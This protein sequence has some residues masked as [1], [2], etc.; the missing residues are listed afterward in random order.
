MK[1]NGFKVSICIVLVLALLVIPLAGCSKTAGGQPD[2]AT[3][4]TIPP[5]SSFIIDFGNFMSPNQVTSSPG[6][7][8]LN[9]RPISFLPGNALS[10]PGGYDIGDFRNWGFAAFNVGI[11]NALVF[12]GLAIP[13]AAFVESFNHTPVQQPDYSWVWTYSVTVH[14]VTYTAELHGKYIE[15]GVRWDMYVTK[16]NEYSNFQWYYGESDLPATQGYWIL[17][18]NPANPADLLRIDWHRDL[19][20][21]TGDIKY[22]NIIP[23]GAENGGYISYGITT[24]PVFNRFYDIFNKGQANHTYIEWNGATRA[25]RVKDSRHFDDDEWHCWDSDHRDTVC[26]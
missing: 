14:E 16:Q 6:G 22:T 24:Q 19:A 26:Q 4:P 9:V 5:E 25:G 8:G 20:N 21:S 2:V 18:N 7:E 23:G 3:P 1:F 17:K 10:L 11:W 12:V 15:Q 13:V